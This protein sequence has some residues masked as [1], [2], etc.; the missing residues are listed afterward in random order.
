MWCRSDGLCSRPHASSCC[1][2]P[3]GCGACLDKGSRARERGEE[4]G[5]AGGGGEQAG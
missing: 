4:R 2:I 5:K 3:E 1:V